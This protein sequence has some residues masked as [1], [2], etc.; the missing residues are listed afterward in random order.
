MPYRDRFVIIIVHI[1]LRALLFVALLHFLYVLCW[2]HSGC[3][4][5]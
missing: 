3:T 5:N 2:D 1:N 4:S